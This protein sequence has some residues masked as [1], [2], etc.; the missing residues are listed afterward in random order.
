M[1]RGLAVTKRGGGVDVNAAW[2]RI[3]KKE[4]ATLF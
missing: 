2:H 3:S 1:H 4:L